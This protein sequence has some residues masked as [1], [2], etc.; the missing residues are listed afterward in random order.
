MSTIEEMATKAAGLRA[1]AKGHRQHAAESIEFAEAD[2][3][4]AEALERKIGQ[5]SVLGVSETRRLFG[6]LR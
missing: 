4:E 2:E 1:Q 6:G 5:R 3:L